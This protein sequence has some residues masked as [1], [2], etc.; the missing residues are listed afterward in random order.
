MNEL[1]VN[2]K[3]CFGIKSLEYNFNFKKSRIFSI[4]AKNG[5]MK[6]SFTKT[7]KKI[8][9]LKSTDIRDE[10][11]DIQGEF[12]VL[13]DNK[14]ITDKDIF[15]VKSF[16]SGYEADIIPL[17][18]D[19]KIKILLKEVLAIRDKLF[20]SLEVCSGLKVKRKINGKNCYEMEDRIIQDL[21]LKNNSFI[22]NLDRIKNFEVDN[23]VPDICYNSIF[24]ES[25]LKKILSSE[26]QKYI[27]DYIKKSEEIYKNY[28]CF[29]KGNLTLTKLKEIKENL[30]KNRFFTQNNKIILSGID[31]ISSY[32]ELEKDINKIED[33]LKATDEFKKI[34]KILG[35]AKGRSLKD[36]IE[37]KPDIIKKFTESGLMELRKKLWYLYF[38]NNKKIFEELVYAYSKLSE[39]INKLDVNNTDWQSALAIYNR[40]FSVPYKMKITN[41][42]G[43]VIGEGIPKVEFE[44]VKDGKIVEMERDRLE[45]LDTLS[46]GEK[47]ALYLLNIIFDIECLKKENKE[48]LIILDD[49][50]DS[51]DYK[52]KYAI[53]EYLYEIA[54]VENF[55]LIILSHNFDF[56][57]TVSSRL[58]ILRNNRLCARKVDD[59]I[60]LEEEKYQKQPF[61]AWKRD[62]NK[63]NV[64]ALIPF[65]RNL[66]EY[67]NDKNISN[68]NNDFE[69]L[70]A[71]LHEKKNTNAITF[72]ELKPIYNYYIGIS[73]FKNDII[74]TDSIVKT[75]YLI[76]DDISIQDSLLENKIVLAMG[77]RHKAEEFMIEEIKKYSGNLIWGNG[78]NSGNSEEF[79]MYIEDGHANQT[80]ELLDAYSSIFRDKTKMEILNEVDI[81]TPENIHI[82]SFMYE[83]ILD[84]DVVELKRLYEDVKKLKEEVADEQTEI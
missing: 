74:D 3:N 70:T 54:K 51:F 31:E 78:R 43:A 42:K 65:V 9:D 49:I 82:N 50:A 16:E 12:N 4:Y 5:L 33:S 53:I 61:E 28:S 72:K 8:Q 34:E 38:N 37:L 44:F 66:I 60:I 11:F 58:G 40:R 69:F 39:S 19:E 13:I 84:M 35:D 77:I 2:L 48:K 27:N 22:L 71:L 45:E 56:Y 18:I 1:K 24:D 36:I 30:N 20:K 29:S 64:L 41:L 23:D 59:N 21:N 67:G 14:N 25:I 73:D 80:R 81:M 6:T 76:C 83:P 32:E 52:N 46:Q 79:I 26:F 62:L 15:V 7:F 55:Y 68:T 10:I 17:L 75:L 57:R 63:T 47:R